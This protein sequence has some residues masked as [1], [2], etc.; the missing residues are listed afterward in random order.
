MLMQR[1][2]TRRIH[3]IV[4]ASIKVLPHFGKSS[5]HHEFCFPVAHREIAFTSQ[6]SAF[7]Y[8]VNF[9]VVFPFSYSCDEFII[10]DNKSGDIQK[11]REMILEHQNR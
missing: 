8:K 10:N 6:L 11:I 9:I 7:D 2:I 5:L 1:Y 3:T 4:C